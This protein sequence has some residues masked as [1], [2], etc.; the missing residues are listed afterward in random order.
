MKKVILLLVIS[1]FCNCIF[2][3]N[4]Q[5]LQ[6]TVLA[7]SKNLTVELIKNKL[8]LLVKLN[9]G[10]KDTIL[11]KKNDLDKL[12][13][14]CEIVPFVAKGK[15]LY[16]V[17]WKQKT[18]TNSKLMNEVKT[19]T[20]SAICDIALKV[21]LFSNVQTNTKTKEIQFIDEKHNASETHEKNRNEGLVLSVT[22][23]G[24]LELKNKVV[25]K[26][27]IYDSIYKK[28]INSESLSQIKKSKL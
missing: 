11:L 2:C 4:K 21:V 20:N 26:K 5:V 27:M 25:Q 28:Y 13:S 12:P 23:E 7:K 6:S 9:N 24:D 22:K 15:K 1:L 14:E 17:T 3:Q 18:I 16:N 10:K 19:I 8:F